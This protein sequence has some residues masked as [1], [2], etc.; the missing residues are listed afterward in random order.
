MIQLLNP[1]YEKN[2][3]IVGGKP[4]L[5]ISQKVISRDVQELVSELWV[6]PH[7]DQEVLRAVA[8]FLKVRFNPKLDVY[9][10]NAP[11]NGR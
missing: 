2:V 3:E 9:Y 1:K 6:S 7:G 8:H 5:R 10:S 11:F 4:R